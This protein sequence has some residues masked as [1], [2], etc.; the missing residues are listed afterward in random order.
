MDSAVEGAD[1]ENR[2]LTAHLGRVDFAR[3]FPYI[4]RQSRLLGANGTVWNRRK[5]GNERSRTEQAAWRQQTDW[6]E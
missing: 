2:F 4:G 3:A 5:I 6:Q 1:D